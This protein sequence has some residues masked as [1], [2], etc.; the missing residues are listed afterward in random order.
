MFLVQLYNDKMS[1]FAIDGRYFIVIIIILGVMRVEFLD[2]STSVASTP[3][4]GRVMGPL[5]VLV[6]PCFS[7]N[8]VVT[9][10]TVSFLCS[11]DHFLL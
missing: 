9:C 6:C 4:K 2:K 10:K 11:I 3:F 1:K 7:E 8:V 5:L